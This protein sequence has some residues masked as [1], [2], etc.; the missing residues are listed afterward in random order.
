[1]A[2]IY[3]VTELCTALKPWAL[4]LLL[5]RGAAV[6][7]YLDPD[8]AVYA[9]L[10]E[11]EKLSLEHGI[12]LTPHTVAPMP[13]DGLTPNEAQIMAAGTYNLG[14]LAVDQAAAGDA[15]LVAGAAAPRL[16]H[17][18]ARDAFR[19]PALG[20]PGA[21]LLP[22][23]RAHRPDVQRR[24]LEPRLPAAGPRGAAPCTWPTAARCTSSTS[25][26]TSRTGRG[27]SRSTTS[28][29]RAYSS[30]STRWSPDC[31]T[32][33]ASGSP[34]PRSAAGRAA[35]WSTCRYRFNRLPDGTR[36]TR[37]MRTA[38]RA[39][40]GR[41]GPQ[42]RRAPAGVAGQRRGARLVPRAGAGRLPHEPLPATPLWESRPDLQASVPAPARGRR[43]GAW[44]TGPGRGAVDPDI[45]VGLLP[46]AA[47]RRF[48][49]VEHAPAWCEPGRL[50]HRRDGRRRDGP[51]ARRRRPRRGPRMLDRPEHVDA[52]PAAAALPRRRPTSTRYPVTVAAVNADQLPPGPGRATL[53]CVSATR[54]GC[55]RGRSRSSRGTTR[56]WTWS[57]RSGRC[58][59]S[60]ATRSRG[61]R[62]S[63]CTSSRCRP[64]SR[65]PARRSTGPRSALPDGP[66]F[67]FA[68][69]YLS[70]FER[71]NPLGLVEAFCAAF[72]DG[73]GPALVLKSMNGDAVPVRP[74]AA[75]RRGRATAA[76]SCCSRTTSTA[77]SS[78]ALMDEC[79]A[80][81]PCTGP[82]ATAS[83]WPR[84]WRA[85]GR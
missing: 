16:H 62:T 68:F 21:W 51:D 61:P 38:L 65:S 76:T 6:A 5:D 35:P 59:R 44:S 28:T 41:V 81:S 3:D 34:T 77:T 25:A 85:A 43:D 13:R 26:A 30:A 72:P 20:R 22:A 54:S 27:C 73:D 56:R 83:R 79:T 52:E 70:V 55:G 15:A 58:R 18:A 19:R 57:T 71:K 39:G 10:A 32:S 74:R 49:D 75:A 82:R 11:V 17:R 80:T 29:G 1:M 37:P 23:R 33:T 24:L 53:R 4:E 42:R 84:R 47:T 14:F 36:V 40:A 9:S 60:P 12:V 8:I 48:R 67:L 46:A 64:A 7:T 50:L 78:S 31:A 66:Y 63:R 2:L 69:D 45:V